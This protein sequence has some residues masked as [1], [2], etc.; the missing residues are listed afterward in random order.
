MNTFMSDLF[1]KFF[2]SDFY[3][4]NEDL[5]KVA[6]N[7]HFSFEE[8]QLKVIKKNLDAM[9]DLIDVLAQTKL[10]EQ[11]KELNL[12]NHIHEQMGLQVFSRQDESKQENADIFSN[13][14]EENGF[15]I[16]PKVLNN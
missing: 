13:T 15:F 14:E 3:L 9:L 11:E 16:S 6:K 5:K 10:E 1:H 2:K 12:I 4:S 8:E 7:V